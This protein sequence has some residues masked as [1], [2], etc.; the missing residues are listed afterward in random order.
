[1]SFYLRVIN[2]CNDLTIVDRALKRLIEFHLRVCSDRD[3]F[4]QND[5][6]SLWNVQLEKLMNLERHELRAYRVMLE[7]LN[8]RMKS[9]NILEPD[10]YSLVVL[11]RS[12]N[13]RKTITVP[14]YT[15]L[16]KFRHVI[17]EQMGLKETNFDIFLNNS[18]KTTF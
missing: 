10:P 17:A 15:S 3:R 9:L 13:K 7:E 1:M 4:T 5:K 16:W 2:K 6:F 18:P 11:N 12:T 8:G 14:R